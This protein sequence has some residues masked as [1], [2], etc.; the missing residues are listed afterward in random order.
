[1]LIY[2]WSTNN[3]GTASPLCWQAYRYISVNATHWHHFVLT[4]APRPRRCPTLSQPFVFNA[5]YLPGCIPRNGWILEIRG[6]KKAHLH[7]GTR[8][9]SIH[10][11]Y[12]H[13]IYIWHLFDA[14]DHLICNSLKL[15]TAKEMCKVY[16]FMVRY[17]VQLG[18]I[19]RLHILLPGH[20]TC[21]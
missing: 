14:H 15:C 3:V 13:L 20:W 6:I 9:S 16:L 4:P 2:A 18:F 21:P 19:F 12:N 17:Q 5:S 8:C 10:G 1:M 11:T 7:F